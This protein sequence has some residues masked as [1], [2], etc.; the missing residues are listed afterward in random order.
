M[1][2][3]WVQSKAELNDAFP[4]TNSPV[5]IYLIL[6]LK[7]L[8]RDQLECGNIRV[9]ALILAYD[10]I[11][12]IMIT[13][14]AL[15][16]FSEI[17]MLLGALLRDLRAKVLMK[18]KLDPRDPSTFKY[19]K[20]QKHLLHKCVHTDAVT[21]LTSERACTGPGVSP[22]PVTA[23]VLL[24]QMPVLVNLPA[25]PNKETPA[26]AYATEDIPST[27]AEHTIDTKIDNVMKAF[28]AWTF[29]QSNV[30]KPNYRGYQTACAYA[31]PAD[32]PPLHTPINLSPP[33]APM[34]HT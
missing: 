26:R 2:K 14:G 11:S 33:S 22:C 28:E 20:L 19:N 31:I 21:L 9:E 25:I 15:A 5:D 24:L 4:N 18:L 32:T 7:C 34:G 1:R 27:N 17:Q 12:H 30:N 16:D 8:S 6:Y 10:N 13:N 29:H 3:Y 23:G